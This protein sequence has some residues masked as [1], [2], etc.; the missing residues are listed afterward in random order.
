MAGSV[1]SEVVRE[2]SPPVSGGLLGFSD[3]PCL[4]KASPLR[5]LRLH[6]AFSC[7]FLLSVQTSPFHK[8]NSHAGLKPNLRAP[9]LLDSLHRPYFQ[10]GLRSQVLGVRT[11]TTSSR[12]T[13]FNPF[14][15]QRWPASAEPELTLTSSFCLSPPS[16]LWC[17]SLCQSPREM[18]G[19]QF[20]HK[21]T[22]GEILIAC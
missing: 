6:M 4:E 14:S 13:M 16:S 17:N 7:L 9:S 21:E 10:I 19:E 15:S 11:L 1:P 2:A 22:A 8:D 12:E 18:L 20:N 5:C 3:A